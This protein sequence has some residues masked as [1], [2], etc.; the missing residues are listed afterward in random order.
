MFGAIADLSPLVVM[1]VGLLC[2]SVAGASLGFAIGLMIDAALLQTMGLSLAGAV[3]VGYW[4]GRLRELRDPQG[5]LAP[6]ALGAGAAAIATI[7]YGIGQ[8]LLGVDAPVSWLLVSRR[9]RRSSSTPCIALPVYALVRRWLAA[10]AARGPAP[11]PAPRLHDRRPVAAAEGLSPWARYY[12]PRI[13]ARR[14][15]RSW[16]CASPSWASSRS[17]CSRSSSSASGTCR[18]WPATQYLAEANQNRARV[19][20]IQAPR[21]DIVDRNGREIVT[22]RLANVVQ[23][24]PRSLPEEERV[25]AAA[26]GQRAG[27]LQAQ[28]EA[29]S[30]PTRRSG[31]GATRTPRRRCRRSPRRRRAAEALRG[32]RRG[33]RR[34]GPR[35]SEAVDPLAG[36]PAL[37]RDHA[38]R[39]RPALDARLPRGAQGPVPRRAPRRDLPAQVPKT[40][41]AAQLLG[42]V[43]EVS[44]EQLKENRFNG[45]RQGT[46][47]GKGGIELAYDR[48]LRGKDGARRLS[49]N[50]QGQ[51]EGELLRARR[52][53][54][55][56]QPDEAVAG[57]APAARRPGRDPAG[58]RHVP[59]PTRARSW[60]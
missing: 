48:Y 31:A 17:R 1:A 38:A 12:T 35:R 18:S 41:L 13:A 55:A 51:F 60:R 44:P 52:N 54:V 25:A 58:D 46:I 47:V 37:R 29:A 30:R 9:C 3:A 36:R 40:T 22:S 21:G 2:G 15:R 20:P 11:P 10:G 43:G 14:S 32:D 59:T 6:L 8:F 23:I 16:R 34:C 53:P 33:R 27:K 26:W 19:I 49:V 7:G 5:A 4:A 28:F 57:P 39:R 50:A 45:V 24:N 56:G 42:N